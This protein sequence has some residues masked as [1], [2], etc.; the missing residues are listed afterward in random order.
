VVLW[1]ADR[2]VER[3]H[4]GQ[5]GLGLLFRSMLQEATAA[6]HVYGTG[7][8]L[9]WL[10]KL[11]GD[12]DTVYALQRL[13]RQGVA[14][15]ADA[16]LLALLQRGGL[17]VTLVD[18]AD[19]GDSPAA[20]LAI[21]RAGLVRCACGGATPEPGTDCGRLAGGERLLRVGDV[22]VAADAAGAYG[23]FRAA[24]Q[25][26]RPLRVLSGDDPQPL[27][28]FCGRDALDTA[29]GRLLRLLP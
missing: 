5:G 22:D 18:A 3:A 6:G 14:R 19:A 24:A 10:D 29:L 27:T 13:I 9:G 11:S 28:L 15:G 25:L 23:R 17:R 2:A 21:L 8:F 4:A 7:V 12:R 1:A 20:A 26:G 16:N